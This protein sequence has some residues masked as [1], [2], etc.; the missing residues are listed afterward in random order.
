MLTARV[1]GT[2]TSTVKHPSMKG[3]KLLIVQP[4]LRDGQMP[5]GDPVIAIDVL[6]AG[7]GEMVIITNYRQGTQKLMGHMNTPV[8][9]T[10]LGIVDE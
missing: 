3:W 9:W 8:H 5:D 10:V 4:F 2:A 7:T 6:G 1:I